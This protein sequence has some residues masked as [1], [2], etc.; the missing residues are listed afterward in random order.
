MKKTDDLTL[1]I[2]G[3]YLIYRSSYSSDLG[4][5]SYNDIKT[6]IYYGFLNSLKSVIKKFPNTKKV[7]LLWDIFSKEKQIRSVEYKE[8]KIKRN[9]QETSP[10][11]KK[12]KVMF[13]QEYEKVY[14]YM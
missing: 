14:W 3:K 4:N 13:H 7:Y 10:E 5:L 9:K 1:L 6:G 12:L 11:D 2:D 8:Y